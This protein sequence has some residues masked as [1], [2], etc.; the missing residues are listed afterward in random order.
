M[1]VNSARQRRPIDWVLV[2]LVGT[3]CVIG[4]LNLASASEVTGQRHHVTQALWMVFGSVAATA[5]AS[6]DYRL[7]ERGAYIIFAGACLLLALVPFVGTTLNN[8]QRWIDL[9]V[10]YLQPS[11]EMKLAAVL[12]TARYLSDHP[13]PDGHSLR[14][15]AP[16]GALLAIPSL[17][18][19]IQPDLG[20]AITVLLI[21]G[22]IVLFDRIRWASLLALI[23]AGLAAIPVMWT[24]VMKP[25][26]KARVLAFLNPDE[27]LQG[28]AWQVSQS[29]IAIGSGRLFGK[30]YMQGTQVQNGFVPEHENDFI[31]THHGEQFGFVGSLVLL[32][33]YFALV[34]WALH[35]ARQGRD[36][37]AVLCAVGIAAFV[38]WHVTINLGMVTGMLPVV[39][40]WL[41]F[42][43]YGGNATL[44]VFFCV[45]ILMSISMRRQVF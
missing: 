12:V 11:E 13:R 39:G 29:R 24:F 23:S 38:F 7:L 6:Q 26:Q 40:L 17:L 45:G 42:A 2:A 21:A 43:S 20:T 25:Y 37:F 5:L 10:F 18:I 27:N 15:L 41:P 35:I 32:G 4:L 30:G 3:L 31:F 8:S 9:G 34:L 1:S 33:L 14:D 16:L 28:D 36:R 19:L 22:T 44:T